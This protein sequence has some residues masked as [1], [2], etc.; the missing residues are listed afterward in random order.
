VKTN[1]KQLARKP[2]DAT[3]VNQ[4]AVVEYRQGFFGN[5]AASCF[6]VLRLDPKQPNAEGNLT[7]I[8]TE[9]QRR[10]AVYNVLL[11]KLRMRSALILAHQGRH[12]EAVKAV[13]NDKPEGH[14]APA[15][16]C[17]HAVASSA[18]SK[19]QKLTPEERG[20]QA[21]EYA[22]RAVEL[23]RGAQKAGYFKDNTRVKYLDMEHDLDALRMRA[24]FKTLMDEI[25]KGS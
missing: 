25:K 9:V 15:L 11:E 16:A 13:A 19:D 18:A 24:D 8:E 12:G 2:N 20:K 4:R 1:G 3:L 7:T 21:E 23:L 5:A 10:M 17:L 6:E 14:V 22:S